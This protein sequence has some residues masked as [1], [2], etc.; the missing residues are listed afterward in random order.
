MAVA[1]II[2]KIS[3]S[4]KI[5]NEIIHITLKITTKTHN[6]TYLVQQKQ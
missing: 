6:L 1:D 4:D 3:I 5:G 2:N